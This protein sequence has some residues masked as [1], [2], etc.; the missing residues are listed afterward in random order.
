MRPAPSAL[1]DPVQP[2]PINRNLIV[3]AINLA[4]N[5]LDMLVL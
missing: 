1:L 2:A 5:A 3:N 4:A